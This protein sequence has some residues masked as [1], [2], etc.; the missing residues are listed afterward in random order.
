M[1][2]EQVRER[3]VAAEVECVFSSPFVASTVGLS[4]SDS[5]EAVLD[6]NAR[7]KTR[8]TSGRSAA[9]TELPKE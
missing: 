6:S 5:R 7:P 4:R 2:F 9:L 8:A 1:G 3:S